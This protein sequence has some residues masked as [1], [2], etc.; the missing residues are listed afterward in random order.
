MKIYKNVFE[1]IISTENLFLA[2][3]KFKKGK[4]QKLDVQEFEFNLEER[5]FRLQR[6][7]KSQIYRHGH[8]KS[9]HI[10]DP[11]PRHIHKAEVQDRIVHHAVFN[12]LNPVFEPTFIS[13]SFSC[14]IGKG[15]HKGVNQLTSF[16]R[17]ASKNNR[18]VCFA[19]KCDIKKFFYTIDH[20]ILVSIIEKRIKDRKALWIVEEII[21]SFVSEY[22]TL[23]ER[24]GLPLGNLTS[25]LF[26]NIYL[27]ELDW[28]IKHK[29]KEKY[30][31]RYTDDFIIVREDECQLRR[32]INLVN[33]FLK[34][35]LKLT[36][37][38]KKI[39]IRKYHQGIDFLGYICFPHYRLLRSKTKQRI[40]KKLKQK[41]KEFKDG[42]ISEQNL[43]QSL[44]SYLG[45]LSHCNSYRLQEKLK[46]QFYFWLTD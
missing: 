4:R 35:H 8:Y 31:L 26:A 18:R 14:R 41:I 16:L 22:S 3:D 27:N 23:F 45:V 20:Q 43:G 34:N 7:L 38:P 25:Q 13:H 40:F 10:Q 5:L 39:I 37:H 28:F 21:K 36:L 12:I 32:T 33:N 11:K 9:F 17:K 15:T 44:Q 2:W 19:L 1:K 6:E 30:Y 24:K 46:N 42:T 29:L